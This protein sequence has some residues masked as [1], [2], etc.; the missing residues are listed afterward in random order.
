MKDNNQT[1]LDKVEALM[2]DMDIMTQEMLFNEKELIDQVEH[3]KQRF[4]T[5]EKEIN[6]ERTNFLKEI[7]LMR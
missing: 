7:E 6:E 2:Q 4:E 5:K 1:L 3:Y